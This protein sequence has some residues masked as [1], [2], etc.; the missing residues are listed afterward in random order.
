MVGGPTAEIPH[1]PCTGSAVWRGP[2]LAHS[3]VWEWH[4]A[5]AQLDE[6]DTA[7]HAVRVRGTPLL[8]ITADRFPLPALASQLAGLADELENGR[9]FVL[10]RRVPVGRFGP[11]TAAVLLWGLGRHLGIPVSQNATGHMLGHIADPHEVRAARPFHT[12]EADTL[13]LLCLRNDSGAGHA[14]LASSAAVHNTVLA[15]RPDL[16]D[17]LYRTHFLDRLGEQAPGQHPCHAVPLAHRDQERFSLRYDR[18]RVESAQRFPGVPR[19]T[20]DDLEL[21]DHIDESA[22]D[23]ELRLDLPLAPG[24]LLL[25]NNHAVLH[26]LTAPADTTGRGPRFHALRLWLTPHRPR[27]LP[28][29]FWGDAHFL[30]GGRGGVAPRDVITPQSPTTRKS[31]DRPVRTPGPIRPVPR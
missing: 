20:P 4:L 25:V 24:D 21:F 10:I 19:L 17:G 13:A 8:R 2:E 11:A 31:H 26:S 15:R 28:P 27:E 12:D 7:L 9:G 22:A 6:L 1:S 18:H 30:D 14:A 5:P 16:V 3:H 23:P 29:D